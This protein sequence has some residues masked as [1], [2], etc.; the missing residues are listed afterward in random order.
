MKDLRK[1]RGRFGEQL[2]REQLETKGWQIIALNWRCQL[3]EIDIVAWDNACL[4]FVE[5]RTR[6]SSRF[7]TPAESV[8]WRKQKKLRQLAIAFLATNPVGA[9]SIRFDIISVQM[10]ESRQ[11]AKLAHIQNAF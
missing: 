5:V 6:T 1:E 10:T 3:G 8:D 11:D 9:R 7:G 4:V 2:A